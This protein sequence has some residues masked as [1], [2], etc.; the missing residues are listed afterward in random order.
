MK[1][2]LRLIYMDFLLA[3]EFVLAFF[4]QIIYL[5]IS[6]IVVYFVWS[7]LYAAHPVLEQI[8]GMSLKSIICYYVFANIILFITGK[9]WYLNYTIWSDINKGLLSIYLARPIDYISYRFFREAGSLIVNTVLGTISIIA[10]NWIFNLCSIS[11][12]NILIFLLSIAESIILIFFFQFLVG[13]L[14]FWT[15]KIFGLRDLLFR[16]VQFLGGQVLPLAFFSS[17]AKSILDFLPFKFIYN[18]PAMAFIATDSSGFLHNQICAVFW[19]A[20]GY[21]FIRSF[22]NYG[23]KRYVANG[24]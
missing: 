24:G 15:D 8:S 16:I 1:K 21:L 4:A 7:K 13:T 17:W 10:I 22:F 12:V 9:F 14:T 6:S 3:K 5:P 23:L 11:I 20:V 2:Y 19:I 18:A